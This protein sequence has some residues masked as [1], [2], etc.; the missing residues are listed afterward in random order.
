MVIAATPSRLVVL[1]ASNLRGS[2]KRLAHS[3]PWEQVGDFTI[4][5]TFGLNAKAVLTFHDGSSVAFGTGAPRS[6]EF[7]SAIRPLIPMSVATN[8]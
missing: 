1:E 3:V 8:S 6:A 5:R 4:E 7:V 2:V